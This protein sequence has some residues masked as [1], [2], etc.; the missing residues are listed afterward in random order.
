MKKC[1]FITVRTGSSRLPNKSTLDLCGKPTIKYLIEN[2]KKSKRAD[3]IILCTTNLPEDRILCEIAS[4]CGIKFHCGSTDDKLMRWLTACVSNSVDF[5]VNIDGDD[6]FFDYELADHLF[7]QYNESHPDF[8]EGQGYL[9]ND[10]YGMK[11]DALSHVCKKKKNTNVEFIKPH[12]N[13]TAICSEKVKAY[14][15][16]WEKKNIRMTLDYEEDLQFFEA[17][18]DGL[19][20]Q[21]LTFD[22]IMKFL[23]HNPEIVNLN[24][25][26]ENEWKNRQ[27][28]QIKTELDTI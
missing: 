28:H 9:Y 5:F 23:E 11:F 6:L 22:N 7:F 21:E 19:S 24:W 20:G 26:M 16:K 3:D 4:E 25:H 17:V 13:D 15:P 12:F 1:I 8:I 27:L 18:I 10:V 14:D 2:L